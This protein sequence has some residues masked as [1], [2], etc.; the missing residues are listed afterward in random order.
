[1]GPEYGMRVAV[2]KPRGI[3]LIVAA[4]FAALMLALVPAMASAK[5][6]EKGPSGLAFYKPPK[7]LPKGHGK[8]IWYA[9]S[10]GLVPLSNASVN[11]NV[12]YTSKSPQGERIAVSGS[13][14]LPEG[15]PPKGGW[16]IISWAHG[17]TGVADV[18]A[19]SR[20]APGDPAEAYISYVN[21]V[22]SD[23]LKA[24]YA[25]LRTD[26]QGL[27]TPGKAPYLIGKSEGRS[28][29]D[30]VRAARQL[31]PSLSNKYVIAGHSQGGHAA[32]FAA[33]NAEK[34]TPE[35]KLEG[36]MAYAPASHMY[37]QALAL[38]SL[39]TPSGL[40]ALATTIVYGATTANPRVDAQ[41]L[42]SDPPLAFYPELDQTCLPQ[43]GASNKLGGIA[44]ADLLRSGAKTGALYKVLQTNNPDVTTSAPILLLQGTA[45]TTVFPFLTDSLDAE[46]NTSGDSV[47]YQKYPG[48]DHGDIVSAAESQAMDFLEANLPSSR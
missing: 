25:V 18:C 31:E 40:S 42:L 21:P 30:I 16:P 45:D 24:G 14:S 39:T 17:T 33:G 48:V 28:T 35:L 32:L 5:K 4:A 10:G 37:Q 1:M 20:N 11:D 34:W 23:W 12:L 26:Y 29:L 46:L 43:L 38:P 3:V 41:K 8:L 47:D 44:P 19:P 7:K 27:G 36:T 13:I 22:L 15:K 6:P 2:R 9:K